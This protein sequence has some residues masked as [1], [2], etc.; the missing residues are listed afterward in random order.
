MQFVCI[1]DEVNLITN[2]IEV[3][4]IQSNYKSDNDEY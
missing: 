1:F 2:Q 3:Q 4:D